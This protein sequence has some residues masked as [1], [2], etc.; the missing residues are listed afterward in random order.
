MAHFGE[1]LAELRQDKRLT[2]KELAEHFHVS[3][4]TISNYEKG[5]HKPDLEM[6]CAL[7]HFF[8]VSTDYL[9]GLAPKSVSYEA[10]QTPIG[11]GNIIG[12]LVEYICKMDARQLEALTVLLIERNEDSK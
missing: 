9:L 1:I 8:H 3:I 6:L 5:V 12:D 11:N 7:A 2:Q 10:F 4:G